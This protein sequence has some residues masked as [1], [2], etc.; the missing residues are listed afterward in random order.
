MKLKKTI[1]SIEKFNPDIR[2]QYTLI[3]LYQCE[4]CN[5]KEIIKKYN[6]PWYEEILVVNIKCSSCGK[7]TQ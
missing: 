1:K 3:D 4:F 6:I 7:S 5:N 2:I